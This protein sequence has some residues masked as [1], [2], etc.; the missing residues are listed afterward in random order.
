VKP[1]LFLPVSTLLPIESEKSKMKKWILSL[2]LALGA[3][4]GVQASS[5]GIAWDKAPN[6]LN[7]LESLQNGA[8]LFVHYCLNCHS[9]AYMR[10]NRLKDIDISEQEIKDTL[11]FT[12]EKVGETMKAAI[13]PRQAKD[14]FGGNP[15]DLTLIAR[16]RAG[17]GG[18]GADY[19]YTYMRTFYVDE[20]K[21]TG[22]NNL[23]FP[24]VGMPHVLWEL[25]GKRTPV[26][27]K[28]SSHGHD[29]EV[30]KG[31]TQLTPG[32]MTPAQYDQAMGDLVGYLQWMAEPVQN[33]RVRLGVW[34]LLFLCVMTV[35]T[36]RLNA[37]FWKD[38]K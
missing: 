18:T 13:D 28:I 37:A 34:V 2:A 4:T 29:T 15:P 23:A 3:A 8:K 10:Y 27:E 6:R 7:D 21:A 9:A 31:W 24:S 32:T 19:L 12:T 36:W 22:W 20:T 11:L 5:D 26:I 38:V 1:N 16:S 17:A 35:I 30:V 25:Q 14:W 33:T